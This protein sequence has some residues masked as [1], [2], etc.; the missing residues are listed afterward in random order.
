M[1]ACLQRQTWLLY[2]E[3][4]GLRTKLFI[5]FANALIVGSLFW[6]ID[7]NSTSSAFSKSSIAFFSIAFVGWLQFSELVPAIGGRSTI[8]RQRVFA[9]YRPSAVV[10]SRAIM[11]LPLVFVMVAVF[12]VPFYFLARLD[13]DV[14]KFWIYFLFVYLVSLSLT[15]MYRML[16]AFSETI[17]D[18]IRWVNIGRLDEAKAPQGQLEPTIADECQCCV[19]CSFTVATSS[20][21][22]RS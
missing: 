12:A 3:L 9:F 17:D 5:L 16:A 4:A 2:H 21:A 22:T 18:A 10:L 11:D 20:H 15:T 19:S 7:E 1:A 8:E 13:V 6:N 14:S